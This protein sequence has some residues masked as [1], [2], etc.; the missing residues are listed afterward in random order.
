MSQSNPTPV[1]LVTGFLGSGKTTFINQLIHD[2]PDHKI[3]LILNEFGDIK[4]ESQFV[5]TKG[6]GMVSELSGGC[7]CCVAS[8]DLPRV[9]RYTL[10]NAPSTE[11]LVIEASG[12]SDPDPVR[13]TLQS[14]DLANLIRLDTVVV[15]VDALNF[16]ATASAHPL[17]MSQIAEADLS[18]LSKS[19]SLSQD[20]V[21][22]LISR[23]SSIGT[24]TRTLVWDKTLDTSIVFDPHLP[25]D[26]VSPS[27]HSH[28]S[29]MSHFFTS[30]Q[31]LDIKR[32]HKA[33][34]QFHDNILRVK[35]YVFTESEYY[36]VQKVGHHVDIRLAPM[37]KLAPTP[38]AAILV[39][40]T[41]LDPKVIDLSLQ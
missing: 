28:T 20:Q 23:V 6:I 38:K 25:K 29:Y 22:D 10:E 12:L 11:Y 41:Q 30:D 3:S 34:T 13:S 7:L 21:E 36:L 39:I 40:G 18:L 27:H 19:D 17:V 31:N 9:V 4:L 8:V 32:V 24:G 26:L 35:G 1:I 15:I 5:E 16:H 14:P 37:P 33:L 2:H